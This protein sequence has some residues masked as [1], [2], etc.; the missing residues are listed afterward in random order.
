MLILIIQ[1]R[2]ES[3][4]GMDRKKRQKSTDKSGGYI[5]SINAFIHS[6]YSKRISCLVINQSLE[7]RERTY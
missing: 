5:E 4:N 3:E 1:Y 6:K 7:V 2:C